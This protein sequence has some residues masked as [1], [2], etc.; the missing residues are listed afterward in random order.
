ETINEWLEV[1]AI[2]QA[3]FGGGRFSKYEL[4][5]ASAFTLASNDSN[6]SSSCCQMLP[7]LAPTMN[8][9]APDLS[10]CDPTIRSPVGESTGSTKRS[11]I[12]LDLEL[13]PAVAAVRHG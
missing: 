1:G 13:F 6:G 7:P 2:D 9:D 12:Y 3:V 8:A 4:Q 10:C 5:T 11:S